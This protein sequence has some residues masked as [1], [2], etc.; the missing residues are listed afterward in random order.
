MRFLSGK[1][2]S[3]MVALYLSMV[4]SSESEIIRAFAAWKSIFCIFFVEDWSEL[5]IYRN[6]FSDNNLLNLKYIHKLIMYN[7]LLSWRFG[8]HEIEY[9]KF[10]NDFKITY[11][12]S[13]NVFTNFSILASTDSSTNFPMNKH[14][15]APSQESSISFT[16]HWKN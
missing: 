14:F 4:D 10:Y 3:K 15:Q 9:L 7:S 2:Y 11:F 5:K 12:S 16:K 13:K 1:Q 8:T 6:L